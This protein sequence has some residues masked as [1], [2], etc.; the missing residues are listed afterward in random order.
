MSTDRI[1]DTKCFPPSS[2]G[3]VSKTKVPTG[4]LPFDGSR[5]AFLLALF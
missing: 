5:D 4:L 3:R 2:E 1:T